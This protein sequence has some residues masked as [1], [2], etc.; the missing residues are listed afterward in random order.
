MRQHLSRFSGLRYKAMAD[1]ERGALGLL[2][3]SGPNS[4]VREQLVKM[5]SDVS[6]AGSGIAA[7]SITDDLA[8]EILRPSGRDLQELQTA[9]DSGKVQPGFAVPDSI[10]EAVIDIVQEKRTTRNVLARL[11]ADGA[12]GHPAIVVGAHV[13]HL[14]DGTGANSLAR[15][16]EKG[17]T[18]YGAD[19]NASGVAGLLEIAQFLAD[20]KAKGQLSLQKD[21]LF[22]A[23][24]AEELGLLGSAYFARAFGGGAERPQL[25][26]DL[27]AYLNLDMIGRLDK[28]LILQGV[29]SSSVWGKEIERRNAVVGLPVVTQNESYLP[30][31]ATSFYLKKVPVL[32][33][34]TGAHEDYHTPRDTPDRLNYEGAQKIAS[35][36]ALIA[37]SLIKDPQAP[38]Y[39]EM[40]PP[41]NLPAGGGRRVYLGTIPDFSQGD[42]VVG[43]KI[44]GAQKGGPA[45][46][47]GLQAGDVIVELAGKAIANIYDYQFAMSGL[48]V[49]EAVS[50][51]VMRGRERLA[52]TITP[53]SRE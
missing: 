36:F 31:D 4:K 13:D 21:V 9:L 7:V 14:G 44:S 29:G 23:W 12:A 47:A 50:I 39:K 37:E 2:I 27:A 53:G 40:E 16:D 24:S 10:V 51:V 20:R 19:D 8:R 22:A 34:F 48:K 45:E 46:R 15:E 41:K 49:G 11:E 35:L 32:S 26:P 42:D 17:K 43:V 33:A 3:A 6:L 18:H 25:T 1:R 38:D 5:T 28:K 52:L 30:T